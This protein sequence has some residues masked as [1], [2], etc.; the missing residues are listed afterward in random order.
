ML[1]I[2][3]H[4]DDETLVARCSGASVSTSAVKCS[5][6]VVTRGEAGH[7]LLA[8]G[9]KPDLGTVRTAEMKRAAK[10]FRA[11]LTLWDLP[12]GGA[13]SGGWDADSG[14]HETLVAR[15]AGFVARKR[16]DV[17]LTFDPRHGSTCHT[18][19]MALGSLVLEAV[20][21]LPNPPATYLLETR[22][23]FTATPFAMQLRIRRTGLR[24]SVRVRRQPAARR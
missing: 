3:A 13:A 7:C 12:D 2:G 21:Q 9:C 16:P 1:W 11:Q 18:D 19:H 15:L 17:V 22:V 20:A 10:H 5:F 4:P 24:G 6:L 8:K 23:T 14:G